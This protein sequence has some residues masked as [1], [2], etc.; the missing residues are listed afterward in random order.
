MI[1]KVLDYRSVVDSLALYYTWIELKFF[2]S[3]SCNV[4]AT[5]WCAVQTIKE[6]C[7][8]SH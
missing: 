5:L 3:T 4:H 6:E 8:K 1:S 7:G 2:F